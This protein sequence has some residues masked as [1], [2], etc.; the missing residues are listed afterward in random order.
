MGRFYPPLEASPLHCRVKAA[1]TS[2]HRVVVRR[3]LRHYLQHVPVFH[4]PAT[5]VEAEDVDPSPVSVA[6]PLL[7]T[8]Q[9]N[10]AVL[11]DHA[12]EMHALARIL[13]GHPL[14][15]RD[16]RLLA[17]G[18]LWIVLGVDIAD[19]LLDGLSGPTLVE[20]QVV[21]RRDGRLV[22]LEAI[23]HR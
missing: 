4:D 10:E 11:S 18:H 1:L 12:P 5:V 14:E 17:I 15:V 22:A 8:M 21:E 13:L 6:G 16:E 23:I 2:E 7:V 20:R 19:V 3:L 9:H